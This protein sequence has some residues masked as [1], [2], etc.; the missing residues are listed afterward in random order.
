MDLQKE[1]EKAGLKDKEAVVYK[2][3]LE[4]GQATALQ[5]AKQTNINRPT[6]YLQLESLAKKGL[7]SPMA[8]GKT[9]GLFEASPVAAVL[10]LLKEEQ[11]KAVNNLAAFEALLPLLEGISSGGDRPRVRVFEGREVLARQ[12]NISSAAKE[13]LVRSIY[14][15]DAVHDSYPDDTR[16]AFSKDRIKNKVIS[17]VIYNCSDGP[18]LQKN[19]KQRLRESIW[20][21]DDKIR[22]SFNF[23][24]YDKTVLVQSNEKGYWGVEI[25]SQKIADSFKSIFDLLW[26]SFAGKIQNV[27]RSL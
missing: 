23:L 7:A 16:T 13:K 9:R 22:I 26:L 17:R 27:V 18:V 6:V 1:L 12:R 10:R 11:N 21:P 14:D 2:V 25:E 3:L 15:L 19:D 24:V 5:V 20:L 8:G 4:M